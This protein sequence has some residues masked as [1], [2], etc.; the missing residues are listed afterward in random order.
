YDLEFCSFYLPVC[1]T[2]QPRASIIPLLQNPALSR[3]VICSCFPSLLLNVFINLLQRPVAHTRP[4]QFC[5]SR[6]T[7]AYLSGFRSVHLLCWV[8]SPKA[9]HRNYCSPLSS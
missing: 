8:M 1:Q 7:A 3:D 4:R 9:P 6:K 2:A 5:C